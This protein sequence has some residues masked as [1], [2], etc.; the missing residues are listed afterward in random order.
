MKCLKRQCSSWGDISR[1]LPKGSILNPLLFL[2]FLNDHTAGLKI[3][4]K[5]FAHDTLLSTGVQV[6]NAAAEDLTHNLELISKWAYNL[7]MSFSPDPEEKAVKPIFFFGGGGVNSRWIFY[8]VF[9]LGPT[10]CNK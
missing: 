2:V 6:S 10:G 9:Y 3:D 8:L 7:R 1:E 4:S 5:P